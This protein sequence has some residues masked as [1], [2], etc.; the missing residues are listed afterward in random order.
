MFFFITLVKTNIMLLELSKKDKKWRHI[1]LKLCGNKDLADDIVQEMYLKLHDKKDLKDFYVVLTIKSIFYDHCR[2]PQNV[3][4]EDYHL[5][6]IQLSKEFEPTDYES[7]L[8]ARYD[9]LSFLEK[10][11]VREMYDNSFRGIAKKIKACDYAFVFRKSTK[12]IKKVLGTDYKKYNNSNLK[13]D[14]KKKNK[15]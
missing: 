1:A 9:K 3:T 12:A 5:H 11:F 8:L 14:G 4:I 7:V 2:K 6:N 13:S 15:S 10:E